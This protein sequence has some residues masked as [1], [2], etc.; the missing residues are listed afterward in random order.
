MAITTIDLD[1]EALDALKRKAKGTTRADV[2]R[3][4]L[5]L[6]N[7]ALDHSDDQKAI[8]I[9]DGDKRVKVIF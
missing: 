9:G 4:A 5:A 6:L 3:K 7:A 2:V 1:L 8:Y